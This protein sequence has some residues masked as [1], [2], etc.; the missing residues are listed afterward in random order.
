MQEKMDSYDE[1]VKAQ[2]EH[3]DD[4]NVIVRSINDAL[5]RNA[6]DWALFGDEHWR[7]DTCCSIC[8]LWTAGVCGHE[9][10]P[11]QEVILVSEFKRREK[12]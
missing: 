12:E 1:F 6:K 10:D 5:E 3:G 4:P 9:N 2:L 11:E 7:E 8:G